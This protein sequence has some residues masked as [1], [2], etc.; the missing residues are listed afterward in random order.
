MFTG[1]KKPYTRLG[2]VRMKCQRCGDK[3]V[4][5]WNCCANGNRWLPVCEACDIALNKMA[6]EFFRLPNRKQLLRRY[7]KMVIA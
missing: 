7:E 6:M 5:Q 1:R 4:F 2:I 3:A